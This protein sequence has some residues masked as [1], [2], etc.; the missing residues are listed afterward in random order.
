MT[1]K[2]RLCNM[3]CLGSIISIM[4]CSCEN[5]GNPAKSPDSVSYAAF[6]AT[7]T[8]VENGS[9]LVEPVEGSPE[10]KSSDEFSIPNGDEITLHAGDVIEI[11]YNGDIMETYPAQLGEVYSLKVIKESGS[12]TG[13]TVAADGSDTSMTLCEL[14]E[15]TEE[16]IGNQIPQWVSDENRKL[17]MNVMTSA[18]LE[19]FDDYAKKI[20]P[21]FYDDGWTK[22]Q[23]GQVYLGQGIEMYCLD[24]SEQELRSVYY[25]IILNGVVVSVL[26]VYEDLDSRGLSWQAGPQLANQFNALIQE[27]ASYD[28]ETAL[29]LGYNR[30]NVIGIIGSFNGSDIGTVWKNYYILDIDHVE[31]KEVD[32]KRIPMKEATKG[33]VVDA[34]EPLCTE[35]SDLL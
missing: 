26:D 21:S 1:V 20:F 31:H 7:I 4:L 34:M 9:V 35:R 12:G 22:E 6:H 13:I 24:G 19:D 32:T 10:L 5:P 33:I 23:S 29:L 16:E 15:S 2:K 25:P 30:N 17:P 27:M 28:T 8:E 3:I 18:D 11:K 14:P